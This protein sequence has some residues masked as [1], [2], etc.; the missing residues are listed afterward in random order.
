MNILEIKKENLPHWYFEKV[1]RP[2]DLD[3]F[4]F[5]YYEGDTY[6]EI[7]INKMHLFAISLFNRYLTIR[8]SRIGND[9]ETSEIL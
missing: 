2:E 5:Y 1:Q 7:S 4:Q 8:K 9:L 6:E 3:N